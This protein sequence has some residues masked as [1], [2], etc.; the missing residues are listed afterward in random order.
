MDA[1]GNDSATLLSET[2]NCLSD[3]SGQWLPLGK[4]R[5]AEGQRQ[6]LEHFWFREHDLGQT[7]ATADVRSQTDIK[8]KSTH[9]ADAA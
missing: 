1:V 8:A 4:V 9:F 7:I 3:L 6:L 5:F 2:S